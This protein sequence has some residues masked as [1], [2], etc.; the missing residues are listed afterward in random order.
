MDKA[1]NIEIP[2]I[3]KR[4]VLESF[5]AIQGV[6]KKVIIRKRKSKKKKK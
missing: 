3:N 2:K 6:P 4:A 5:L 1:M